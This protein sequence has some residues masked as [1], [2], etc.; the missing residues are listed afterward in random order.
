M[1]CSR[2]GFGVVRGLEDV[3]A[4]QGGGVVVPVVAVALLIAGGV[5]SWGSDCCCSGMRSAITGEHSK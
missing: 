5:G 2:K 3:R 4:G 1:G